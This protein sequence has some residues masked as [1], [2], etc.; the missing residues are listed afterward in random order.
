MNPPANP[1]PT[2]DNAVSREYVNNV[3]QQMRQAYLA[4]KDQKQLQTLKK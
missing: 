3:L 2:L 1:K 4:S